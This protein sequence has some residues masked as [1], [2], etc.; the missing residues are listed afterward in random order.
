MHVILPE[1]EGSGDRE[2]ERQ[3]NKDWDRQRDR[4]SE[5]EQSRKE[6]GYPLTV[7]MLLT[8]FFKALAFSQ[9]K[10]QLSKY[11]SQTASWL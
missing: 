8:F 4:K 11:Q 2:T 1:T 7:D 10:S 5:F 3:R 9:K 6:F